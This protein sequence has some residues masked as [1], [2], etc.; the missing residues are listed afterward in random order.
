MEKATLVTTASSSGRTCT[1][2]LAA[3]M[4]GEL[5]SAEDFG[6]NG[7]GDDAVDSLTK[8]GVMTSGRSGIHLPEFRPTGE[9]SSRQF[10][11]LFV[12]LLSLS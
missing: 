8:S 4:L 11:G 9:I 3:G 5:F 6:S 10:S 7:S 1:P 2:K 12:D